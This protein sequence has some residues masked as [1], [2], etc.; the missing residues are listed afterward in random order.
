[1]K[2]NI[3]LTFLLALTLTACSAL[4]AGVE[5]TLTPSSSTLARAASN[6]TSIPVAQPTD[7]LLP[8]RTSQPTSLSMAPTST[9]SPIPTATPTTSAAIKPSP[10]QT[11]TS[12]PSS[13][14]L[15][16]DL[17]GPYNLPTPAF[18]FTSAEGKIYFLDGR[19]EKH[20]VDLETFA[21][22]GYR[23]EDVIV[24]SSMEISYPEGAPFTRLLKGSGVEVYWMEN[25][26]RR[27]IPD[28]DTFRQR[29]YR[30][31]DIFQ[32]F[33]NVLLSWP[34]GEP[35]PSVLGTPPEPA[36]T[37]SPE[38]VVLS[39]HPFDR[40]ARASEIFT[41]YA[42]GRNPRRLSY[43]TGYTYHTDAAWSPD[44]RSIAFTE[45]L[46]DMPNS[47]D[48]VVATTGSDRWAPHQLVEDALL[49]GP[50][51]SPDGTHLAFTQGLMG[52]AL[53]VMNIDGGHIQ[54]TTIES[55]KFT[56]TP[57]GRIAFWAL[58]REAPEKS[59]LMTMDANG[60]NVQPVEAQVTVLDQRY[61]PWRQC[62]WVA[63]GSPDH[64]SG[65]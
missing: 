3:S 56:W 41:V 2:L 11:S 12:V 37:L 23:E 55:W 26:F 28:M 8:T 25:D 27:H 16:C 58:N 35:L 13:I 5:M 24:G 50:V 20:V 4:E 49:H 45:C 10:G 63:S 6:T 61:S 53:A 36:P 40:H 60:Q 52:S 32:V 22:L 31:E 47:T 30:P 39:Y 59:R 19:G 62:E 38:R 34:L 57:N 14:G 15:K 1:M 43:T 54:T 29:G 64:P 17:N 65:Q 21:N 42:D 18:F 44:G 46:A 9:P 7:T 51:W 33:D 48:C